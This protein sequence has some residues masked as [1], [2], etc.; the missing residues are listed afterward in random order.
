[1]EVGMGATEAFLLWEYTLWKSNQ[2]LTF[3]AHMLS[4]PMRSSLLHSLVYSFTHLLG[5]HVGTTTL[6]I[7]QNHSLVY[8]F[9]KHTSHV[10][11]ETFIR[12][13]AMTGW[14]RWLEHQPIHQKVIG[15][16]SQL[17]HK[18]RLRVRS[19]VG[20][21]PGGSRLMFLSHTGVSLSPPT[22]PSSVSKI[23]KHPQVRI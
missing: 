11:L 12:M 18:P 3:K 14:L 21:H 17:G 19:L 1:M 5:T 15:S 7:H 2:V 16:I 8:T 23:N 6:K 20:V 9:Q 13:V 22:P 10:H 4:P